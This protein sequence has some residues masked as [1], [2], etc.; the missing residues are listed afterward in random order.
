MAWPGRVAGNVAPIRID[1]LRLATPGFAFAH[2]TESQSPGLRSGFITSVKMIGPT[3]AAGRNIADSYEAEIKVN[4]Q[5]TTFDFVKNLFL[6]STAPFQA[7]F[8][9]SNGQ[10]WNFT[11]NTAGQ[12]TPNGST[13]LGM[14]WNFMIGKEERRVEAT[15]MGR[16]TQPE[17]DWL[18]DNLGSQSSGGSSGTSYG[19]SA[20]AYARNKYR[21]ANFES[22]LIGGNSVGYFSDAKIELKG[23]GWETHRSALN[24]NQVEVTGEV[25]CRQSSATEL[26]ETLIDAESDVAVV[27]NTLAGE[28][29]TMSAGA[30]SI[31]PDPIQIGDEESF[32]KLAFKGTVPRASFTIASSAIT[33]ALVGYN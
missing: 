7:Q 31:S 17:V 23:M 16:M 9:T 13:L 12:T 33:A 27:F 15:L 30:V 14:N 25:T 28:T 20:H 18:N 26:A 3:D 21:R 1:N 19:L 4:F 6:L 22:V 24:V 11:D 2:A 32:I 10:W 29:I 5:Q 8:Q